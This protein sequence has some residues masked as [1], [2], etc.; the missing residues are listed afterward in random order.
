MLIRLENLSEKSEQ[1]DLVAVAKAFDTQSAS[2]NIKELVMVVSNI[3]GCS[4]D[5]I[6]ILLKDI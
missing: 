4:L 5:L 6:L 3:V 2:W 1:V